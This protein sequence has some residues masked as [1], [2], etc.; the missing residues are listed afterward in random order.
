MAFALHPKLEIFYYKIVCRSSVLL[1]SVE[2]SEETRVIVVSFFVPNI[3]ST[4][5][6]VDVRCGTLLKG[7]VPAE[8]RRRQFLCAIRQK[9]S[10]ARKIMGRLTNPV[11]ECGISRLGAFQRVQCQSRRQLIVAG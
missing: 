10:S 9:D 4:V 1:E 8:P 7:V 11:S 2:M 3:A 6:Y 5:A